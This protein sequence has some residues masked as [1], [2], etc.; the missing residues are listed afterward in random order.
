MSMEGDTLHQASEH[1]EPDD[2]NIDDVDSCND[3]MD[4]PMAAAVVA[5]ADSSA[6]DDAGS[7]GDA[8]PQRCNTQDRFCFGLALALQGT[9]AACAH[10]HWMHLLVS[11]IDGD[12]R[13]PF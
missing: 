13:V 8:Y 7:I 5:A 12:D 4:A 3:C 2:S 9:G 6:D 1:V 10:R 11:L